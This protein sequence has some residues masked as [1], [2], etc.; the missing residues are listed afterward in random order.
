MTLEPTHHDRQAKLNRVRALARS[1]HGRVYGARNRRLFLISGRANFEALLKT[2]KRGARRGKTLDHLTIKSL[3]LSTASIVEVTQCMLTTRRAAL[4]KW[5]RLLDLF[6]QT[7]SEPV[8]RSGWIAKNRREIAY[9]YTRLNELQGRLGADRFEPFLL[10]AQ[11]EQ[12]LQ[13][14]LRRQGT[15]DVRSQA[16]HWLARVVLWLAGK[17]AMHR[18]LTGVEGISRRFDEAQGIADI[19]NLRMTLR[20]WKN[21]APRASFSRLAEL[22]RTI[23]PRVID[24]ARLNCRNKKRSF[25]QHCSLLIERC[26]E[27]LVNH[28]IEAEQV[29]NAAIA[30]LAACDKSGAR[31]PS[32]FVTMI[33]R[34]S[35][36]EYALNIASNLFR[37]SRSPGYA[38]LLKAIDSPSVLCGDEITLIRRRLIGGE[39]IDDIRWAAREDIIHIFRTQNPSIGWWRRFE[40]SLAKL[41]IEFPSYE[42]ECF[43][44]SAVRPGDIA[45]LEQFVAWLGR[46][47]TVLRSTKLREKCFKTLFELAAPMTQLLGE[48]SEFQNWATPAQDSD[49]LPADFQP[50]MRPVEDWLRAV[51]RFQRLLQRSE[52]VPKSIAKLFK[53]HASWASERDYLEKRALNGSITFSQA[54]RLSQ[55][56]D[57]RPEGPSLGKLHRTAEE[58][59]LMIGLEALRRLT[60][61]TM[62]QHWTNL[63]DRSLSNHSCS[64]KLAFGKWLLVM[65]KDQRDLLAQIL[66][67]HQ[68]HGAGYREQFS[69][70]RRWLND[71]AN[72]GVDVLAWSKPPAQSQYV[73]KREVTLEVT[74]D[75]MEIFLM[76]T[77]FNSC[78]SLGQ[79]N[80]MSVLANAHDA[81]KRV[82]YLRDQRN[83]VLGRKLVA[84]NSEFEMIGYTSYIAAECC[85]DNQREQVAEAMAVYCGR[86][87]RR[88]RLQLANIGEPINISGQFW[89]D[90]EAT[91]WSDAAKAAWESQP[92]DV[93][94][95]TLSADADC[96]SP[97]VA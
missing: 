11:E 92:S 1:L 27:Y 13:T 83:R 54:R 4:A 65:R 62:E 12:W 67:T 59:S 91:A 16:T 75:P 33:A 7:K 71:A 64:R 66:R 35:R 22:M 56:H 85:E 58:S 78:L 36:P 44:D 73:G 19:A 74:N 96:A 30:S 55:L 82:L 9:L 5:E 3:G 46:H 20:S 40:R 26:D 48:S 43:F 47:S 49:D 72:R 77:Y 97:V 57:K 41:G 38:L 2:L 18:Y 31:L 89:Y 70:N 79:C 94:P 8:H 90:D 50:A 17:Q 60:S 87:A 68:Q 29:A 76:G 21:G 51:T 80:Q 45:V 61:V 53:K 39:T 37:E 84:V 24:A 69:A 6:Q 93:A 25:E 23:S 63:T 34:R 95:L 15:A 28:R 10:L 52:T 81:N 32:E 14:A 88:S 42:R 86:W